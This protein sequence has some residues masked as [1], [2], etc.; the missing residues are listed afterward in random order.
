[1]IDAEKNAVV[2]T[3]GLHRS[4]YFISVSQDGTRGYVANAGSNNVSVIDLA[5]RKVIATIAVGVAP[6]MAV[7]SPDGKTVAAPL[8]EEGALAVIDVPTLQVRSKINLSNCKQ[9][10]EITIL[11]DSSKAFVACSTGEQVAAVQLKK[12][13]AKQEDDHL[14]ALLNVGKTP[15]HLALKP[16]GGEIFVSNFDGETFS[17][18]ATGANEVGGSY[19]IGTNPVRGVVGADNA[20]LYVSNFGSDTV[21]IYDITISKLLGTIH[22]GSKPESLVLSPNQNYLFVANTRSGDVA[23]IRTAVRA[24]FTMIPVGR[25]PNSMVLKA[26]AVRK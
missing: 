12:S 5:A 19:M 22:V 3:I 13:E 6:G 10:G 26:F 23:V 15:I 16:D 25:Q 17:E 20:T 14:L 11:P 9:P 4:P 1:V 21:A 2:A 18:I 24:L 7:V 8:R